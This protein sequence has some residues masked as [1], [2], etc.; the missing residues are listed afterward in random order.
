MQQDGSGNDRPLI[1]SANKSE[2]DT[3]TKITREKSL[4]LMLLNGANF[5]QY[6]KVRD[7]IANQF[8]QGINGYSK[9]T[10][11]C[12]RLPNNYK[13]LCPVQTFTGYQEEEDIA[14]AQ[15]GKRDP[16]KSGSHEKS[17][18][19]AGGDEKAKAATKKKKEKLKTIKC[20]NCGKMGHFASNCTE[21]K[22]D[23]E[24]VNGNE[25]GVDH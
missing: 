10:E 14:F 24:S 12:V 4:A 2:L 17:N 13:N 18:E 22:K 1:K 3:V 7:H 19:K 8:T 11:G 15:Q 23:K 6:A 16:K 5:K 25:S 9:A 21:E 20:F